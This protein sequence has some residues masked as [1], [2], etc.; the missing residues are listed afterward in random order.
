LSRII[1]S[2]PTAPAVLDITA[3]L[4]AY[5]SVSQSV[6]PNLVTSVDITGHAGFPPEKGLQDEAGLKFENADRTIF[7]SVAAY[8]IKRTDVLVSSGQRL[9]GTQQPYF[10]L[11]GEQHSEGFES[12]PNGSR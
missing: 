11:D 12:R 10:R 6:L 7:A 9:P 3:A 2:I 4:S 5:A 8:F 1:G